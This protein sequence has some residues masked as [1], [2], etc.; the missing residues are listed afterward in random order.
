MPG[1]DGRAVAA[2]LVKVRAELKVVFMSGYLNDLQDRRFAGALF[3]QKPFS[4]DELAQKLET[5]R[6]VAV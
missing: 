3:L 2:K 6:A 1:E 4:R 5:A